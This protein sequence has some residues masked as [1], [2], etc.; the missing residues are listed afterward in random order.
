MTLLRLVTRGDRQLRAVQASLPL[1][2]PPQQQAL[3]L[4]GVSVGR[5]G[6]SEGTQSSTSAG[7]EVLPPGYTPPGTNPPPGGHGY[8]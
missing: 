6:G 7:G 1:A 2:R 8:F 5:G 3:T 4:S